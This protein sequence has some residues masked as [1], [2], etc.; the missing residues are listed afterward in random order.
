[1]KKLHYRFRFACMA[2]AC[3]SRCSATARAACGN[4]LLPTD[5][6]LS[7]LKTSPRPTACP[8][9]MSTPCWWMA[10]ASGRAPKTG[11][12]LYEN[13]AVEDLHDHGRPGASRGAFAGA[14]QAHR[15]CVGR[16]DGRV[17]PHLRRAHRQLY[18]VELRAE[19]R[20][21]L[22]RLCRRA[23]TCGWPRRLAAAS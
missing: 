16:N 5:A 1:M 9:I 10:T 14:G 23:K 2:V 19:Q 8:T 20:R 4:R 17:E 6:A 11:L 18:A 12:A 21:G 13:H 22:R 15:R 7:A 3:F